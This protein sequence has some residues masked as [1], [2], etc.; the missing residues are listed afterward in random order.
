MMCL[1]SY[2][3]QGFFATATPGLL[4]LK[5]FCVL[6]AFVTATLKKN[7]NHEYRRYDIMLRCIYVLMNGG[8]F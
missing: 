8:F 1:K 5:R 7:P 6:R 3:A 4:S 2:S